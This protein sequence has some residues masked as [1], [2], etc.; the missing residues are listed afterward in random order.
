VTGSTG[1][2]P[3]VGSAKQARADR[4]QELPLGGSL[5]RAGHHE[6]PRQKAESID[7]MRR[8]T[9]MQ[10]LGPG[11]L[12]GAAVACE[13]NKTRNDNVKT[14]IDAKTALDRHEL[15]YLQ[16]AIHLSDLSSS[17]A[18]GNNDPFGAVLVLK[19]GNAISGH[20]HVRTDKD[21]T[22]HAELYTLRQAC[23]RGLEASDFE[24][25][26]LY[27]STEPCAMCC[28]AIYWVG[29]RRVVY[30]CGHESLDRLFHDMFPESSAGGGL[31]MSS[32]EIFA[33]GGTRTDVLGP[34]LE[35]RAVA[36]HMK[37]WPALLSVP[38]PN[39]WQ[40]LREL[41]QDGDTPLVD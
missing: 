41:P 14:G 22:Q 24:G 15:E 30:G 31:L 38:V 29:I 17:P 2:V 1:L 20:N 28:G 13:I 34:Y 33:R 12:V 4:T 26:T 25:A 7:T 11:F 37:H 40:S 27:T 23:R 18:Y 5:V 3:L 21:P 36:V 19:D 6:A 10:V 8:R 16:E 35:D 39:R 9:F 32:R